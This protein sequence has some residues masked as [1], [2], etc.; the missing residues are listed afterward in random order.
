MKKKY[1]FIIALTLFTV[2][3][4]FKKDTLEN[5]TI[6]TTNYP[7]EYITDHL[8]GENANIVSIYPNDVNINDYTLTDKQLT[9]YSKGRIF[10]YN[11]LSNEKN[12]A[13]SMLN[14]N[15]NLLIIDA[16]MSMDYTYKEEEI[17]LDPS[18][19]LMIAQNIKNGFNEYI[20]STYLKKEIEDNYDQLKIDLSEIDAELNLI[21]ENASDK[22]IVVDDDLLLFLQKYGLNVLS[23]EENDNLTAKKIDDI[24]KLI[25]S[26]S[27][28]YIFIK[29]N[30]SL[31]AT[32]Q[33]LVDKYGI[34]TISFKTGSNLSETEREE[35]VDFLKIMNNNIDS[36]KRELYQ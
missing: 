15:D 4:C 36:L 12:Y 33:R 29:N 1:W 32:A 7:I 23:L 21:V 25:S 16:A 28:K 3:G 13:I 14:K 27:V 22:N 19:F 34:T 11:G 20:T 26:G 2:T 30:D 8:Y 10:I 18:N 5:V 9:D 17:W 24:E 6:Y 35:K 31:N